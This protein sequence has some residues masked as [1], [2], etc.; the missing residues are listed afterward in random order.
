MKN[1]LQRRRLLIRLNERFGISTIFDWRLFMRT[2]QQRQLKQLQTGFTLIELIIVIVIIGI[3]AAV[4][5]PKYQSLT[6]DARVGVALGVAGA[7]ASASS[8]NYARRAGSNTTGKAVASCTD[9]NLSNL[10]AIPTN[11]SIKG[12]TL[13]TD[14]TTGDCYIQY[15]ST[16]LT[17]TTTFQAYGSN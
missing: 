17:G 13:N 3:L 15:D 12:G 1:Q 9:T 11:Y 8:I 6:D 5:I 4:A 7:V 2:R 14:G 10:V 16:N